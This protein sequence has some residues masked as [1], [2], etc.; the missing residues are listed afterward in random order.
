MLPDVGIQQ[1]LLLH[2]ESSLPYSISLFPPS[3]LPLSPSLPPTLSPSS[4]GTTRE[5]QKEEKQGVDYNFISVEEFKEMERNGDFVE[6]GI[7]DGNYHGIAKPL[8]DPSSP[9][10][11][12]SLP[13][14]SSP[15][16]PKSLPDLSS[17]MPKS[18]PDLSSEMPKPRPDLSSKMPKPRPDLSSPKMPKLLGPLPANWEIAYTENEE[19]FFIE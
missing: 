7:Y 3:T 6:I 4:P 11:P 13:D 16:M 15:K 17:E 2:R 8:P 9:K 19:K 14:S 18:L 12:K 10:M 1:C 5:M